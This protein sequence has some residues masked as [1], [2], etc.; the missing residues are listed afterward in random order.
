MMRLLGGLEL[1]FLRKLVVTSAIV[2]ARF[3]LLGVGHFK[4]GDKDRFLKTL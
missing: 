4:S 3:L 2:V 1:W